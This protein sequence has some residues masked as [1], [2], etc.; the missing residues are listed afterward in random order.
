MQLG[1]SAHNTNRQKTFFLYKTTKQNYWSQP[2]KIYTPRKKS[3]KP[4]RFQTKYLKAKKAVGKLEFEHAQPCRDPSYKSLQ[5]FVES[6]PT[7]AEKNFLH[8]CT[9][10]ISATAPSV[11]I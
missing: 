7:K 3:I 8:R 4:Y 5:A 6:V 10:D 9:V 1:L 2:I 11:S